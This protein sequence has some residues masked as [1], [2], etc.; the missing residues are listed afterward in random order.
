LIWRGSPQEAKIPLAID[1]SLDGAKS[2]KGEQTQI[3]GLRLF[4]KQHGGDL[5]INA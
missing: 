5:S 4:L 3:K 1:T 2:F